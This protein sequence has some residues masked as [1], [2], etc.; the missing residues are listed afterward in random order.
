MSP[1]GGSSRRCSS[2]PARPEDGSPRRASDFEFA[3]GLS[4]AAAPHKGDSTIS[5]GIG[6][7]FHGNAAAGTLNAI[8]NNLVGVALSCSRRS[9]SRVGSKNKKPNNSGSGVDADPPSQLP[10]ALFT[11]DAEKNASVE[12]SVMARVLDSSP[13]GGSSGATLEG[14]MLLV[15][16]PSLHVTGSCDLKLQ[17][18]APVNIGGFGPSQLRQCGSSSVAK[19]ESLPIK[20]A[21]A[22]FLQF[23]S[24]PSEC[25]RGPQAMFQWPSPFQ[26]SAQKG[27]DPVRV[28]RPS[29]CR[30]PT[31]SSFPSPMERTAWCARGCGAAMA[32]NRSSQPTRN[33]ELTC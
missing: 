1:S 14:E 32:R 17:E 3:W 33:S 4:L 12:E 27:P 31:A 15:P 6:G 19:S 30:G 22:I 16:K 7:H 11:S 2:T 28:K 21:T 18:K 8:A 20:A 25:F 26:T 24:G 13:I 9:P 29:S 5:H 10:Q 23:S